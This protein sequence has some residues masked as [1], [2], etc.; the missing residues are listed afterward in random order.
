MPTNVVGTIIKLLIASLIVGV[1]LS[2]MDLDAMGFLRWIGHSFS[3]IVA[4]FGEFARWALGPILV[5]AV[6][7]VPIWLIFFLIG[8]ARGR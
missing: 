4:F 1:I 8:R 6:L 3:D 2:W 7:V 5:G